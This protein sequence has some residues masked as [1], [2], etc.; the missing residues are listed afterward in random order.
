[1]IP[2]VKKNLPAS[3]RARLLL[4]AHERGEDFTRTLR[5][6]GLQRLL[7]RMASSR[8]RDS[9]ILK[10][11]FLVSAWT[12][13]PH[14]TT[15]DADF[16]GVGEW[17]REGLLEAFRTMVSEREAEFFPQDGLRFHHNTLAVGPI[18]EG[19]PFGGWRFSVTADLDGALI[20]MQVDVGLGET[21]IPPP[22]EIRLPGMLGLPAAPLLSCPREVVVAEKFEIMVRLALA[23]SRMK[24]YFDLWYFQG[25]LGF[26]GARLVSALEATFRKRGTDVP[27]AVPFALSPGFWDDTSK[28]A[29]WAGFVRK[30]LVDPAGALTLA[31]TC[32]AIA[33][34]I[35]PPSKA[36][37]EEKNFLRQWP[38][39]GKWK[40]EK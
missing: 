37:S 4:L 15:M 11:A 14:R 21:V 30:I 8:F 12:G 35:L 23:N 38:P 7:H 9:F 2:T 16:T 20:P 26:D 36:L 29:Q 5:R 34:F 22:E 28:K 24:D 13:T 40:Q 25:H 6:F 17:T 39:G 32:Q 33:G 31:E 3:L 1:M 19:E 27:R 18:R 10:G